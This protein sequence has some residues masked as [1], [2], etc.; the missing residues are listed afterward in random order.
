MSG[1]LNSWIKAFLT[2]RKGEQ[3]G[4][5]VLLIIIILVIVSNFF[6]PLFTGD[7]TDKLLVKHE[8]EIREFVEE[9]NSMRDSILKAELIKKNDNRK[10]TFNLMP[11]NPNQ[12]PAE[13]WKEMGFTDRQISNIKNYEAAGGSFRKPSDLKKIYAISEQEFQILEPYIVIHKKEKSKPPANIDLIE[14]N[15]A[16]SL[17]LLTIGVDQTIAGR[18]IKYRKLLGGFYS[19]HQLGEVYGFPKSILNKIDKYVHVDIN[20]I[21]KININKVNFK[22]LV[23]HPYFKYETTKSII[24]TRNKIGSF[25]DINQLKLIDGISDSIFTKVSNYLYIRP[26]NQK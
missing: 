6:F 24:N 11:F 15:S 14:L 21:E 7:E 16:D 26:I 19:T 2:L 8:K 22:E 18:T 4:I 9:Q 17:S 25:N 5:I 23:A 13:K 1:L 3:R 20:K 10:P 12:L